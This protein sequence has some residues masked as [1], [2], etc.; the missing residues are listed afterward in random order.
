MKRYAMMAVL[1]VAVMAVAG[2]A[3]A[4]D[5]PTKVPTNTQDVK[6]VGGT[7]AVQTAMQ[8]KI[9]NANCA[10]KGNTMDTTCDL[11]KLANELAAVSRGSKDTANYNVRVNIEAG[12][13]EAAAKGKKAEVA[14]ASDRATKVQD[15]L[16]AGLG[17]VSDSWNYNTST[18]KDANKLKITVKVEK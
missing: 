7:T 5:L 9:D 12:P 15:A 3:R 6:D 10:F 18:S 11:K 1:V 8:K 14:S 13:G 17:G 2:V 16:K 4:F